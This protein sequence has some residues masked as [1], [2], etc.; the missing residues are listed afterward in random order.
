MPNSA[1]PSS[2]SESSSVGLLGE[3]DVFPCD[4]YP[5]LLNWPA[6]AL[7]AIKIL[8][9]L[10]L[11]SLSNDSLSLNTP[12]RKKRRQG[13]EHRRL[14][15]QRME[16]WENSQTSQQLP[17]V[18]NFLEK[19][20]SEITSLLRLRPA[21]LSSSSSPHARVSIY[22]AETARRP[23]IYPLLGERYRE[24]ERTCLPYVFRIVKNSARLCRC[25]IR[26]RRR[27]RGGNPYEYRRN[28]HVFFV[29]LSKSKFI[30]FWIF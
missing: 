1:T 9:S 3:C 11:R 26:I 7:R 5:I 4:V 16:D 27:N 10:K 6:Y 29:R 19:L 15:Y 21:S 2:T 22:T 24:K 30:N 12:F 17:S 28:L 20:A 23:R 13:H 14:R 25:A 18:R 8:M